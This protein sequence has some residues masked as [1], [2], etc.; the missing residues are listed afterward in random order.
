MASLHIVYCLLWFWTRPFDVN[1]RFGE[2]SLVIVRSTFGFEFEVEL[3]SKQTALLIM[4]S[5]TLPKRFSRT[6]AYTIIIFCSWKFTA[7]YELGIMHRYSYRFI[8]HYNPIWESFTLYCHW[9]KTTY[10][11]VDINTKLF[12]KIENHTEHVLMLTILY[13]RKWESIL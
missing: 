4:A 10:Y 2:V 7:Y 5:E 3:T 8:T 6:K 13:Y 1:W 11:N 12:I 9:V